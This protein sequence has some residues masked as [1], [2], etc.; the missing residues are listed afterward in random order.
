MDRYTDN[1]LLR[2]DYYYKIRDAHADLRD[3]CE[4]EGGNFHYIQLLSALVITLVSIGYLWWRKDPFFLVQIGFCL[5]W[6]GVSYRK[7]RNRK[8]LRK[9]TDDLATAKL[10]YRDAVVDAIS[11]MIGADVMTVESLGRYVLKD[12]PGYMVEVRSMLGITQPA[13]H[14]E[15]PGGHREHGRR[16]SW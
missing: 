6:L 3:S 16:R 4:D 8:I 2:R 13:F 10:Q 14:R 9:C 11:D 1:L 12:L 5:Y 15:C 7:A